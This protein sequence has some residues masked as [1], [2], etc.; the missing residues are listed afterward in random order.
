MKSQ[1]NSLHFLIKVTRICKNTKG[2]LCLNLIAFV[3]FWIIKTEAKLLFQITVTVNY[4][5]GDCDP[6][7]KCS[8]SS[9]VSLPSLYLL[10]G[11]PLC[12]TLPSI[13]LCRLWKSMAKS[14]LASKYRQP[15]Y[16]EFDNLNVTK[17]QVANGLWWCFENLT[18]HIH[19]RGIKSADEIQ[20]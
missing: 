20:K 3:I 7:S 15:I 12:C 13:W 16:A 2:F 4:L 19:L 6:W 18:C 14:R 17:F 5:T 1:R 10:F 8:S 9:G 11:V